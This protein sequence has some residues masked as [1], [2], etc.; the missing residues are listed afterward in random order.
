M[1]V[2][3]SANLARQPKP[4]TP[5]PRRNAEALAKTAPITP[6]SGGAASDRPRQAA[7]LSNQ[8]GSPARPAAG[9]ANPTPRYPWISRRRG[10]EGRVV[11]D[12]EVTPEGR[13]KTVRV[14]RTSG[15]ERLDQS[16]LDAVKDW[17]FSP[18]RRAGRAVPARID[19]PIV[20][21][22]TD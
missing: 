15:S 9:L 14:K 11:L 4:P 20:F 3:P 12:V 16:A 17:R 21:R 13:A 2:E 6:Q 8:I 1:R 10:E 22:L 7:S 18:A 5:D 19:V